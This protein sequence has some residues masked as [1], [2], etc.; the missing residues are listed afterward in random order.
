MEKGRI[1]RWVNIRGSQTQ[2]CELNELCGLTNQALITNLLSN[3][4]HMESEAKLSKGTAKTQPAT[5]TVEGGLGMLQ[6]K[7]YIHNSHR[8]PCFETAH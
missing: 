4:K 5:S 8:R 3:A 2:N 7:H 1:H 6:F